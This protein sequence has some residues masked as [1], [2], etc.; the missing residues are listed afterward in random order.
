MSKFQD[1]KDC[2]VEVSRIRICDY[3]LANFRPKVTIK[4][5]GII[6]TKDNQI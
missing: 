4:S 5:A 6:L 1:C 3:H 2:I